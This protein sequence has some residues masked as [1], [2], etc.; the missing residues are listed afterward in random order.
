MLLQ[1]S[2]KMKV[3]H[4][5]IDYDHQMLFNIANDLHHTVNAQGTA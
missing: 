1:W 3:G 2:D 4:K 5:V